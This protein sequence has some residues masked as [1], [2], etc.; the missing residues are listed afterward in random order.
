[1]T[2]HRISR[3]NGS[4]TYYRLIHDTLIHLYAS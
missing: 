3:Q 1:M 4:V 2:I